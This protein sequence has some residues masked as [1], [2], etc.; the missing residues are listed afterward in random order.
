METLLADAQLQ[1]R[2]LAGFVQTGPTGRWHAH[3]FEVNRAPRFDRASA[4]GHRLDRPSGDGERFDPG[5]AKRVTLV[6]YG[7]RRTIH[8]FAGLTEGPAE[9]RREAALQ[10]A[11]W[12][13]YLK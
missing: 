5:V 3:F 9:A 13:G 12:D 7:G 2:D 1:R 11:E 4:Y 8:G 6:R 10:M